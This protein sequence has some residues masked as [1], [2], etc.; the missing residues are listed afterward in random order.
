MTKV[1]ILEKNISN[2]LWPEFMLV[3]AYIKNN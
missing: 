2:N 1:I 3:M